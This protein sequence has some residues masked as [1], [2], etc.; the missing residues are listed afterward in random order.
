MPNMI[1]RLLSLSP[2]LLLWACAL[3]HAGVSDLATPSDATGALRLWYKAPAVRW[4][5]ALPVGNGRLGAMI[6]GGV[7]DERLQLNEDTLWAGGPY[8]PTRPG[9][10]EAIAQARA[11]LFAG[12]EREA[13]KLINDKGMSNPKKQLPYQTLGDLKLT[14]APLSGNPADYQRSLDLDTAVASTTYSVDGVMYR[15]DVFSSAP[16]DVIVIHLTASKPASISFKAALTSP[17]RMVKVRVEDGVLVLQGISGNAQ[18][19]EGKV[20]FEARLRATTKGGSLTTNAD[21]LE[22]KAADEVTLL[23]SAATSYVNWQ[24]VSGDPAAKASK[25]LLAAASMPYELLRSRH[26]ADYR[27]LFARVSLDLPIG[28]NSPLPTDERVARFAE[29]KDPQLAA[30]FFQFGRYLL[31]SSSRPGGQ[32][33]T[34]Q[35]LWNDSLSPPWES[36]YTININTEMNYW[37]AETTNLSECH[38]PLFQMI[39]ELSVSGVR[40][41]Q[42]FWGAR[43]WMAHHNT[44][45]WRATGP[46]DWAPTGMWPM[47]GAWL[48]THL[49]EHYQFTG[50]RTF[51]AN[52]YPL[53]K[54]ACLFFLDTLVEHPVYHWLVTCP[55]YSPENGPLTAGPAMDNQILR[56]LFQQTAEAARLL[57]IEPEFRAQ[58]L[59]TRAKLAPDHIGKYGQLQEWLEDRDNPGDKNRHV[60]QLYALFPSNQISQKTPEL[61]KA[62]RKSLEFRGDAG[63]GWSLGWKI[64][65]WARLLDGDHAFLILGNLLSAPGSHGKTFDSGGG[66]FPNLFDAHDAEKF[67][68]DGNFGATSGIAEMLLQ[69]Q[70]GEI[71]LLPALPSAWPRGSVTGLRARGGFELD[72]AWAQGKLTSA[73]VRSVGG[74]AGQLRY[75]S[76]AIPLHLAPGKSVRLNADLSSIDRMGVG[77]SG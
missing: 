43:G 11:L 30:L 63:T 54:G 42:G 1:L 36:K 48:C 32:P 52:A 44:D 25:P 34:L 16:D 60:S 74:T 3:S 69:S 67:Q 45:G 70:N 39:K 64:N 37:P 31:I 19:I 62:A 76:K 2:L 72:I 26:I 51:L 10:K 17:Q 71:V 13:V 15:R 50:D 53:M 5:E 61:F 20:R 75:G 4:Q 14:F 22:V 12:K 18:G 49:W 27:K 56:D 23:L 24:D 41:A 65:F 6:F 29:G 35:G 47:G 68:I 33:A 40:S 46:I 28:P 9:A 73:V 21:A 7:T 57:D 77:G 38:E 8:D 55:S 58:L 66:V 59:A